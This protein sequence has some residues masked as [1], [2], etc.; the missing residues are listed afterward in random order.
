MWK[1]LKDLNTHRDLLGIMVGRN[2]K[3]RYKR[4][5][6]GFFWSLLNPLFFIL[7]YA[8]FLKI[9]KCYRAD[10][11]LFL[12]MLVTGVITWQFLS[13]CLNDSLN[14][15]LGN[16]N[17]VAR[18][19]FP[20]IIL[21]MSMSIANLVNFL[22]SLVILFGYAAFLKVGGFAPVHFHHLWLLPAV[23]L[24]HFALCLGLGLILSALNVFFRDTEHVVGVILLAWFFLTPVI[25][26]LEMI[27]VMYQRLAFLNP[28]TGIVTAYRTAILG[29]DIIAPRLTLMSFGVAW[30]VC[31]AGIAF[32]QK[33]E[34]RFV[35]EF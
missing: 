23:I 25:Y 1:L 34:K 26:Y 19:V 13:M 5:V 9:L 12:P 33:I 16:S 27:P 31:I 4:S 21:P 29:A 18:S 28:M 8:I 22:F 20:R 11:L 2:L 32:F 6:L 3:I 14:S 24:T 17:L 35:D 10:D 7:I 15:I 30:L